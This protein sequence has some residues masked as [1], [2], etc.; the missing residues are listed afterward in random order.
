M[1]ALVGKCAH[2]ILEVLIIIL[3]LRI[4]ETDVAPKHRSFFFSTS[5]FR[6][7]YLEIAIIYVLVIYFWVML[8]VVERL[9]IEHQL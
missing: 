8:V 5:P 4:Y 3:D 6:I 2:I 9:R 1:L 7:R